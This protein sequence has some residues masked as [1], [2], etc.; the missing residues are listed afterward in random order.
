MKTLRAAVIGAGQIA[1]KSHLPNYQAQPGVEVVGICDVNPEAAKATAE[2][3]YIPWYGTDPEVMF[4]QT[5]P[6]VV[7]VCVPNRFHAAMA[8]AALQAGCHVLCEKPP[9]MNA[10]QA[11]AMAALAEKKHL[12]LSYGFHLR[13]SPQV[14]AL[15]AKVQAG[16]LGTIYAAKAQWLRRRGIPGWGNFTNRSMQGGGPLIDLGAHVLDIALY[17]L[18]YPK[19][20]YVCAAQSDL[21]GKQGGTGQFG[22]W[23]G[24]KYTVEDF[25][26]GQIFFADGSVLQLDTS[27]ALNTPPMKTQNVTLYGDKLGASLFPLTYCN[28]EGICGD[29]WQAEDSD[30]YLAELQNFL[31]A[32]RGEEPLL[33]TAQQ[34]V[35]VQR[36]IDSLYHSAEIG[37]PVIAQ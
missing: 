7:S 19:I 4:A 30:L 18:G 8:T 11:T 31:A 15:K 1:R 14:R 12:L 22:T 36:V 17:L 5:R 26:T 9:A 16:E 10:D 33:V 37:L 13:H 25:L 3:F 24:T 28:G 32:C 34:G 29:P 2:E 23:D 20:N 27:F 6:D 21:I 35:Y